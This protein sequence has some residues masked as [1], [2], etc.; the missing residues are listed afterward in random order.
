M[1]V[2]FLLFIGSRQRVTIGTVCQNLVSHALYIV[3]PLH[4]WNM[5]HPRRGSNLRAPDNVIIITTSI[6]L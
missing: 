5:E 2:I 1:V 3:S 4:D 6:M